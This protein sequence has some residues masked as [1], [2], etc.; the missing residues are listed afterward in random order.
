MK[1][2]I[3]LRLACLL[4]ILC[5]ATTSTIS[6]TYAKYTT[7]GSTDD[8]A[9]VAKFGVVL[10]IQGGLFA[11]T[12]VDKDNGNTPYEGTGTITVQTSGTVGTGDNLVAPGTKSAANGITFSIKGTPEVA[13]KLKIDMKE[14][15]DVFLL[16]YVDDGSATKDF[17]YRDWTKTTP[18]AFY[19]E[20]FKAELVTLTNASSTDEKYY[21]I[22]F[23]LEETVGSDAYSIQGAAESLTASDMSNRWLVN[24]GTPAGSG[25]RIYGTLGDMQKL[26]AELSDRME[27]LP[28]NYPLDNT[29]TLTWAWDYEQTGYMPNCNAADTLLGNLAA[30][31]V[32]DSAGTE[33]E[34]ASESYP[35]NTGG[36]QGWTSISAANYCLNTGF[37]FSITI[38]QI[39]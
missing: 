35:I 18:N 2:N 30:K 10:D 14:V 5:L 12:Y 25:C 34:V 27:N 33:H 31:K 8:N 13:T 24:P 39:D 11:D 23:C 36:T 38:T 3:W 9:R 32:V 28:A 15:K 21:P 7:Q 20:S 26:F 4:L 16:A 19:S 37:E 22:V 1:K 6:S 29:F 17:S